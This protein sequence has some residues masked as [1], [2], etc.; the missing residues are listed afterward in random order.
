MEIM[1]P[2]VV[3]LII[4]RWIFTSPR[5]Q[6]VEKNEIKEKKFDTPYYTETKKL[7]S[8]HRNRT[9]PKFQKNPSTTSIISEQNNKNIEGEPD[10]FE[11]EYADADGVVTER[12]IT[13]RNITTSSD[14]QKTYVRAFC[15]WRKSERTFRVDRILKIRQ[16]SND[17]YIADID[18]EF[19]KRID[20]ID[21]PDPQHNAVMARAR[22]SLKILI[23]ISLSDRDISSDEIA[24]LLEFIEDRKSLAGQ[25][26]NDTPWDRTKATVY[27]DETRPTFN[28]AAGALMKMPPTGKEIKLV[29]EYATRIAKL[30]GELAEKRRQRLFKKYEN[31]ASQAPPDLHTRT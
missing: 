27:I 4:I 21:L 31:T 15:H 14:L 2:I 22:P 11:I 28:D 6:E 19:A 3:I 5:T 9:S 20:P 18:E 16:I 17:D 23:W 1:I 30:D 25:K 7:N 8:Q 26:Y 13:V 10:T 29:S 24:V 12:V